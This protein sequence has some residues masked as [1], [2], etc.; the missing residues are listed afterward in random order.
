LGREAEKSSLRGAALRL[1]IEEGDI[2]RT[3]RM[4]V[5]RTQL[6]NTQGFPGLRNLGQMPSILEGNGMLR[7]WRAAL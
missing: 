7:R 6:R 2:A 3:N 1:E 4:K 5:K